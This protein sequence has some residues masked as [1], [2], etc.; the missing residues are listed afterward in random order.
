MPILLGIS[1]VFLTAVGQ[2]LLK[3]GADNQNARH[4]LNRFV[5]SGYVAFLLTI[6]LSYYLM[7]IIP[8]KYFTTIMSSSYVVVMVG[9]RIFLGETINRDRVLGTI[10]ITI[11][12]FIFLIK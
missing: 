9:S 7:K 6:V 1:I 12:I 11:G 8:M 10:L 3:M 2:I 4:F 5:I